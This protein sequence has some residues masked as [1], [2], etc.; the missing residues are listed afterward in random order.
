MTVGLL[1][2]FVE[3]REFTT[4]HKVLLGLQRRFRTLEDY[5]GSFGQ[6]KLLPAI[7]DA[8]D[9]CGRTALAWAVEYGWA[10]AVESLLRY[11][12]NPHQLRQSLQGKSPLLHLIIADSAF[13]SS[14]D[15]FLRV[16]R[17]LLR[18]GVDVN[19][20]DHE[21]WTPLHVAAS[22]NHYGVIQE[23]ALFGS[24]K[25]DW[26]SMTDDNQSAMDLSLGAGFDEGVR[27]LL[28]HHS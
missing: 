15:G 22:W 3:S 6:A 13:Q 21:G 18:E 5:L 17:L 12:A 19:A 8:P 4:L 25:L 10:G 7:I 14:N 23:L 11:G 1:S 27:R 26:D 20:V 2:D 9:S 24:N 16:V 28:R